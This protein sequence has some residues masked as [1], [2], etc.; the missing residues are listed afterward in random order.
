[1]GLFNQVGCYHLLA[2]SFME[3]Q[4]LSC[5]SQGG[6][7]GLKSGLGKR[8]CNLHGCQDLDFDQMQKN[9]QPHQLL[10]HFLKLQQ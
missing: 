10:V 8:Q 7:P 2:S 3:L 6:L 1:M 5:T 4:L 9:L